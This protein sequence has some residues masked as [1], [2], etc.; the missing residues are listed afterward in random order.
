MSVRNLVQKTRNDYIRHVKTFT[1]FLGRSPETA[2]PEDLR[3]FQLHQTQTGVR[4]PTINGA[5]VALRFFF[6]VTREAHQSTAPTLL[7]GAAAAIRLLSGRMRTF[8]QSRFMSTRP[9][10]PKSCT[11]PS[12]FL[13]AR[14]GGTIQHYPGLKSITL[15]LNRPPPSRSRLGSLCPDTNSVARARLSRT[16]R[17]ILAA[18]LLS[19]FP[20]AC[21]ARRTKKH[22]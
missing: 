17:F 12:A 16:R 18:W 13:T 15:T 20:V 2:T 8:G 1:A 9:K 10:R 11:Y 4:P 22:R 3:R 6:T 14:K 19:E 21:A 5:V 7:G